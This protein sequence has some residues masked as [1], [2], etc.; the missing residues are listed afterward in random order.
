MDQNDITTNPAGGTEGLGDFISDMKRPREQIDAPDFEIEDA[1]IEGEEGGD[2]GAGDD[3]GSEYQN[4]ALMAILL[5]DS[6]VGI[7]GTL[8]SGLPA[9]RYQK[10]TE[11]KPP[12]HYLNATAALIEKYSLQGAL[13][14]EM[15]FLIALVSVYSGSVSKAMADRAAVVKKAKQEAE[16]QEK[17]RLRAEVLAAK[18]AR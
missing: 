2:A 3:Q 13:S 10:F 12:K 5:I 7:L 16:Q 4:E 15:V 18:E 9:D 6:G 11:R 1:E 17:E 14:P 8:I